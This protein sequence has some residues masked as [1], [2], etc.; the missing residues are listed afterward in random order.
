MIARKALGRINARWLAMR[1]PKLHFVNLLNYNRLL[2]HRRLY[3]AHALKLVPLHSV[4]RRLRVWLVIDRDGLLAT[5]D[6]TDIPRQL[7]LRMP[8]RCNSVLRLHKATAYKR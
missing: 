6:L 3:T 1:L 5:S 2:N 8:E 4:A 7:L